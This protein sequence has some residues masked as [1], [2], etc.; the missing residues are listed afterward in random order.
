[1]RGL[2]ASGKSTKAKEL[3]EQGN[4]VRLNRDLLR[5]MLHADKWSGKNEDITIKAEK[6]LATEFLKEGLRVVIDDTNLG[7]KHRDTWVNI[8]KSVGSDIEYIDLRDAPVGKCTIR[9]SERTDKKPVG[10]HVIM[11]MALQYQL[12]PK[13]EKGF[14]LCDI[15]G[16]IAD[17]GHRLHYV[18]DKENK[19]WRAF[20]DEMVHDT[21]RVEVVERLL[22]LKKD[23][24]TIVFV[25][26]RPENYRKQTET[27]INDVFKDSRIHL[28]IVMRRAGDRR[29]D[30]E[31]KQQ[32]YDT[33]FKHYPV[34]LVIDDRPSVIRMWKSN[35]LTVEDVGT[36]E[37]F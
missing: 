21:P 26:A 23:G 4:T 20:F 7:Q 19:N 35:G 17:V 28:T 36:G 15:D 27:W 11:G 13:P 30:T 22:D 32:M 5:T 1:M 31:V 29:P 6:M 3:L 34:H 9:D 24:Y 14:V 37:E 12:L 2:P 25:T 10:E 8:A 18:A 16:T 33:Y